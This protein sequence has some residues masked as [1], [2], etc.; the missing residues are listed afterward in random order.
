[1]GMYTVFHFNSELKKE[2]PS[3]VINI[4]RHMLGEADRP[5]ALPD[6]P[7]FGA[8]SRW[9]FM[10]RTD[11][12]YFDEDTHSTLRLDDIT[13]TYFLCVRC[14]FKNYDDEIAQFLDWIH[15]YLEKHDGD[16]LG[17]SRYEESEEPTLIH[18]HH[19]S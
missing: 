12:Y 4:I 16:F 2:T 17:F 6:H 13:K 3:E 5:E 15:P 10:L 14:N 7:L 1:M 9:P 19:P 11:S 8:T 18:Y